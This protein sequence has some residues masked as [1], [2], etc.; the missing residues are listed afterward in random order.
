LAR[1]NQGEIIM[2]LFALD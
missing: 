2:K 1:L